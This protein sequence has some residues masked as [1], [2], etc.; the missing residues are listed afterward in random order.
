MKKFLSFFGLGGVLGVDLRISMNG[1]MLARR[2]YSLSGVALRFILVSRCTHFLFSLRSSLLS[3]LTALF[4]IALVRS[5]SFY[6]RCV[7]FAPA[8]VPVTLVAPTFIL[9]SLCPHFLFSL[10]SSLLSLRLPVA[11]V[12]VLRIITFSHRNGSHP[13]RLWLCQYKNG[14]RLPGFRFRSSYYSSVVAI[15]ASTE[16]PF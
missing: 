15:S 10:R 6:S 16:S 14:T 8:T 7:R 5:P 1:G 9:V 13:L 2:G 12:A 11:L 4:S 3:L